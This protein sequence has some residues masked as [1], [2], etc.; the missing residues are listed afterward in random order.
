MDKIAFLKW[1]RKQKIWYFA[2]ERATSKIIIKILK[3][4]L[5]FE[6]IYDII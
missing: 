3:K 2:A 5:K 6:L 1:I 4:Y